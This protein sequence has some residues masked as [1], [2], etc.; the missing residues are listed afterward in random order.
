[1][2]SSMGIFTSRKKKKTDSQE[3]YEFVEANKIR[4]PGKVTGAPSAQ[5]QLSSLKENCELIL[6]CDRQMEEAKIEYQAVTSYLTD[7]QRIDMILP[8]QREDL[9]DAARKIINL[10]KERDKYKKKESKLSK[11]QYQI[12]E[13]YELQIPRDLPEILESEKYQNRIEK[14]MGH[15]MREKKG[16]DAEQSDLMEKQAFLKGIGITTSIIILLL[17]IIFA[18]LGHYSDANLT[19]PFLLTVCMGMLVA[20]YIF[21]EARR[22]LD[23]FHLVQQKQQREVFLMNKVKIKAVN[24]RNYLEYIYHK[25]MVDNYAQFKILW[26]DFVKQKDE[27]RRYQNNTELLDFYHNELIRELKQFGIADAEIWIFQASA[28]LDNKEMVEVRHRL[29]VRRQKLRER[30]DLNTNQKERALWEIKSLRNS[31][32]EGKE[33]ADQFLR[34]YEI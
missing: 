18:F 7:M 14:D 5:E 29:N 6:A 33:A 24:N 10:T 8:D 32:P 1:M 11:M 12:Y 15:L 13:R 3:Q 4:S 20:F 25:Y 26:E 27:E 17:F 19:M 2:I 16:L 28:I 22:N 21:R 30:I 23:A 9:E 34:R 31:Y